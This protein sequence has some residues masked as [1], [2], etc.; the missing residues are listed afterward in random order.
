VSV[1]ISITLIA[2][3]LVGFLIARWW[4]VL[5]PVGG[6]ALLYAGLNAGWW[7]HGVG[8]GWQVAM[9]ILMVVGAAAAAGGATA[10]ALVMPRVKRPAT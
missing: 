8:D 9:A 1:P 4:A 2:S 3:G 7:G 6:L 5:V 10:R